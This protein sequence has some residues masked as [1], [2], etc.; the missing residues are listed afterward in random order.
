MH[1]SLNKGAENEISSFISVIDK[2]EI[3]PIL[4]SIYKDTNEFF[5][6]DKPESG[7]TLLGIGSTYQIKKNGDSRILETEAKI[8]S[9]R[10]KI[11]HNWS[12]IPLKSFPFFMGGM[13]F[14]ANEKSDLWEDYQDSDWFIP[15]FIVLTQ[16]I[17]SFLVFNFD[18]KSDEKENL[19]KEFQNFSELISNSSNTK[20]SKFDENFVGIKISNKET[21]LNDWELKIN[22]ALNKIKSGNIQKIVLSR[23]VS[24]DLSHNPPI[25]YIMEILAKKYPLCYI[26][27][28]KKSDSIFFGASPEMLAKVD[29]GWIEADAL[30]GSSPRGINE[31]EDKLFENE[32]LSSPKNLM[33]QKAVVDFIVNAFNSF[34]DDLI[35]EKVPIIRKLSNIQHLW[36]PIRAK[37]KKGKDVFSIIKEIHPTPAICGAPWSEA[38]GSIIE[39]EE[40][41]RGLFTGTVGWFNFS[42]EGEFAVAI[43]SALIKN[44]KLFAFAGCGIVEGSDP[45]SEFNEAELKLKPILS[46]FENDSKN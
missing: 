43:R 31:A 34:S 1:L 38:L 12:S 11:Y 27:A 18:F 4:E 24:Q 7:F 41:S 39:M 21:E 36:T 37:L 20:L 32:L 25:P 16:G 14:A 28:F 46:L 23:M 29:D 45:V 33:E 40:H 9:I 35:F 30:A 15:R 26:F 22:A 5:Y 2:T 44:K 13:K 3:R 19:L 8:N 17:E 6:W 10:D 42:G